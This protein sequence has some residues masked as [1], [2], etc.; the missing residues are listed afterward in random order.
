[1]GG[2][3]TGLA[4]VYGFGQLARKTMEFEDSLADLAIRGNKN[5]EWMARAREQM[6]D[7]SRATGISKDQI[8]GFSI[9][10][11]ELTGDAQS[12]VDL[13]DDMS[14]V[15]VATGADIQNLASVFDQLSGSLG[16]SKDR[17]YDVFNILRQQEKLG[18]VGFRGIAQALP[19]LA[20]L[21]GAMFR[22]TGIGAAKDVGAL[23]QLSKRGTESVP[24]AT[25]AAKNFLMQ[26][27]RKAP[28]IEKKLGI[29]LYDEQGNFKRLSE[30]ARLIGEGLKGMEAK[31][32][33][34]MAKWFGTR[35]VKT[36]AVLSQVAR[37]GWTKA[38]G[39]RAS[40]AA[41]FG[42]G[43]ADVLSADYE[44][45]MQTRGA[46]FRR[47]MAELEATAHE[48]FLPLLDKLID[49]MPTLARGAGWLLENMQTLGKLWLAWKASGVMR[50]VIQAT[51]ALSQV[52]TGGTPSSTG[53]GAGPGMRAGRVAGG[54]GAAATAVTV[55][56]T[57]ISESMRKAHEKTMELSRLRQQAL[58]SEI[59]A[60]RGVLGLEE[61][62]G[63]QRD[64]EHFYRSNA[65]LNTER[66]AEVARGL[67]AVAP[68]ITQAK[69]AYEFDVLQGG[70]L[71]QAR[72]RLHKL[73]AL[74]AAAVD[75]G[76]AQ[77]RKEGLGLSRREVAESSPAV[78][79]M[80]RMIEKIEPAIAKGMRG[81]AFKPSITIPLNV[82]TPSTRT[83]AR[84][85]AA[86]QGVEAVRDLATSVGKAAVTQESNQSFES[87][88]EMPMVG[89]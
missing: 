66:G 36:A 43:S 24:E 57:L 29:S 61:K 17:A 54:F 7:V 1:L 47:R 73:R 20:P 84:A 78:Q 2:T 34:K 40:A 19:T 71:G 4:G 64:I 9:K 35:G 74:R 21:A 77:A 68:G 67:K 13:L 15:A 25:T 5:N 58:D 69:G 81:V 88:H 28:D 83:R 22:Q 48:A 12:S 46:R 70:G 49:L 55:I 72:K 32:I 3:L 45:R 52:Q 33:G 59:A 8:A 14:K 18:A 75:V 26:V 37:T 11:T 41:L 53:R 82:S 27:A 38:S 16:I 63:A 44:R 56:G 79:I 42:A 30:I 65:W 31:D 60:V 23:L 87:R 50:N 39:S 85:G 86:Q 10:F 76:M 51:A 89:F 62:Y 80:D 6:L